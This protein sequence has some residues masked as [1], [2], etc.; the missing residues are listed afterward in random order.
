MKPFGVDRG[1]LANDRVRDFLEHQI[2]QEER[3][4]GKAIKKLG[5][6]YPSCFVLHSLFF[7]RIWEHLQLGG[8]DLG[9]QDCATRKK[10]PGHQECLLQS[11]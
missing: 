2:L 1:E 11:Q 10:H 8:L 7:A 3:K 5:I 9:H 6:V 4:N